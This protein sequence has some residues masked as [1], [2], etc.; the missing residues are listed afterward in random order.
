ML[1]RRSTILGAVGLLALAGGCAR[2]ANE[3]DFEELGLGNAS[4]E[5]P[6]G[7]LFPVPP[8]D[9]V[10]VHDRGRRLHQLERA[11]VLAYEQGMNQVGDPGTDAVLPLVDVDPGGRSAQVL[12]VRWRPGTDGQLPPL[13]ADTA[14]RWLMVSLLLS[15]DQVLDVEILSG[16]LAKGSHLA[17]RVDTL[18][19]AAGRARE[20]APGVVFHF[21]DVYEQV[22]IDPDKPAKGDEVLARI[23][24]LSADGRG[25]DVE[26][27][28]APPHRRH[29]AEVRSGIVVH[30]GGA[31]LA[32]PIVVQTPSPG[33]ITVVRAM[34]RGTDAGTIPVRSARGEWTVAAGTGLLQRASAG[35]P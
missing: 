25:A 13:R 19:A 6:P 1:C 15:P 16:K 21:F 32:D 27:V 7:L 20:L 2:M 24:G 29:E 30:E 14:E 35:E 33:P 5:P 9:L 34:Q 3:G 10:A 8:E 28:V 23:Y 31:A 18:V 4:S 12:F 26:L 22:P 11:L 17:T